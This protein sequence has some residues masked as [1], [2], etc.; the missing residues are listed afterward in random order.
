MEKKY[1]KQNV[2]EALLERLQ[3]IFCRFENDFIKKTGNCF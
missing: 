3:F 2:Y 1:L